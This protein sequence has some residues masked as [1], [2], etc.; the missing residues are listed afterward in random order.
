MLAQNN[1]SHHEHIINYK[2]WKMARLTKY[3]FVLFLLVI[4]AG[5]FFLTTWDFLPPAKEVEKVIDAKRF[6]K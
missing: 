6:P 3:I 1:G 4:L 2:R 5:S